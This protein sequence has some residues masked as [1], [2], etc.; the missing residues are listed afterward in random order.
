MVGISALSRLKI[1]LLI[2]VLLLGALVLAACGGETATP[3]ATTPT[4]APTPIPA[5]AT[6]PAYLAWTDF[7][8]ADEA[9]KAHQDLLKSRPDFGA[10]A[11]WT[12][13]NRW[14]FLVKDS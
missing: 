2:G 9:E 11:S 4:A 5:P 3:P 10:W 8:F 6:A 14:Y 1:T 7:K 13:S 12:E